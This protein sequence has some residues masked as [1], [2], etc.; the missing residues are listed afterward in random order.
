[1][2][3][4][5]IGVVVA[6]LTWYVT[7]LAARRPE[8]VGGRSVLQFHMIW[9]ALAFFFFGFALLLLFYILEVRGFSQD[10]P[11]SIVAAFVIC[12]ISLGM[13]LWVLQSYRHH[14]VFYD[15]HDITVCDA[16]GREKKFKWKDIQAV[17]FSALKSSYTIV[18]H[19]GDRAAV[20]GY[21]TGVK[22]FV[23]KAEAGIHSA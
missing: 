7:R 16:R 4:L 6:L 17:Q 15:E 13:G 22:E 1:M 12:G 20:H 10:S 18:L 5:V 8:V 2:K 14:R 9:R 23:E 21:L 3:M 19:N 11:A